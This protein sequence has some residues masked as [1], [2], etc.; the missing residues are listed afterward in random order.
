MPVAPTRDVVVDASVIVDMLVTPDAGGLAETLASHRWHAPAHL[1]AEV[2]SALR[3]LVL[4]GHLSQPRA[5]DA[6]IDFHD[7]AITRWPGDL[8]T[9]RRV[10]ALGDRLTA[11]DAAYVVCAEG[12]LAPL[13]TRDDRL[14]RTA[15]SLV[16]LLDV[17]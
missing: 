13:A 8:P 10:L 14:K 17:G 15:R 3:G 11:Y 12:L 7:L 6:L 5:V 4:G 1:D 9:S 16:E 2:L